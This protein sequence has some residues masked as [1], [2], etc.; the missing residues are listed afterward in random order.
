MADRTLNSSDCVGNP[1]DVG[2]EICVLIEIQAVQLM[3]THKFQSKNS[4]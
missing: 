1:V 3:V 2:H 4:K